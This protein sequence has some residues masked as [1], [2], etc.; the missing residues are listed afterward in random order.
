MSV[1]PGTSVCLG[2]LRPIRGRNRNVTGKGL[3]GSWGLEGECLGRDV[4]GTQAAVPAEPRALCLQQG[5]GGGCFL[6]QGLVI[7]A[8]SLV[9]SGAQAAA[10]CPLDVGDL[11]SQCHQLHEEVTL[12]PG[13]PRVR[14]PSAQLARSWAA[15]LSTP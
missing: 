5:W 4:L 10:H 3:L 6:A 11:I 2:F 13:L 7:F 14:M 9:L 1:D 8:W 12:G 15:T